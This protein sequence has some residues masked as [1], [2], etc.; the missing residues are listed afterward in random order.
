MMSMSMAIY[1]GWP[2]ER[3]VHMEIKLDFKGKRYE[4]GKTL[5][6]LLTA[7]VEYQRERTPEGEERPTRND[8]IAELCE[9]GLRRRAA[10]AR[11]QARKSGETSWAGMSD[12]SAPSPGKKGKGKHKAKIA[13]K[14]TTKKA[15][16]PTPKPKKARKPKKPSSQKPSKPIGIDAEAAKVA[17]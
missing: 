8:V 15:K 14:P 12:V 11:E 6:A 5:D 10:V 16:K 17:P 7:Y 13:K 9:A 1:D 3:I 2:D 4:G